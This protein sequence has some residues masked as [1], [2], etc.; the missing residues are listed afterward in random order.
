M[1]VKHPKAAPKVGIVWMIRLSGVDTMLIK[2][3]DVKSMEASNWAPE[4]FDMPT[5]MPKATTG[6]KV[7]AIKA[8]SC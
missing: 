8:E 1:R 2:I 3:K 4:A 6:P 7:M 5:N